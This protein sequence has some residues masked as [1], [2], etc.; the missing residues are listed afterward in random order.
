MSI[1]P[2]TYDFVYSFSFRAI[3]GGGMAIIFLFPISLIK[4]MSGLRFMN[5]V[6]ILALVYTL[7][8]LVAE[9]PSYIMQNFN[10][11]DYEIVYACWDLNILI[12]ASLTFFAYNCQV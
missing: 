4:D 5:F 10:S 12:G 3:Q 11:P 1:A 8:V 6:A 7:I 9:M 2:D